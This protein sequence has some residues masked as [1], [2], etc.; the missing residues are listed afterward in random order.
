V[1]GAFDAW[2]LIVGL[3]I[4]AGLTWLVLADS[5]RR[6]VDVVEEELPSEAAWIASSLAE[7]GVVVDQGT[8]ERVLRLHRTYLASLPPDDPLA[9]PVLEP[10]PELEPKPELEPESVL[11][12]APGASTT[13]AST[14]TDVE[15]STSTSPATTT[16]AD[17]VA[18][19]AAATSS[20]DTAAASASASFPAQ[21]PPAEPRS[22][23]AR[24]RS[25]DAAGPAPDAV[26]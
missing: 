12:P 9:E 8:A 16:S 7:E 23:P 13:A 6:E 4:G 25:T 14:S 26:P 17:A 21:V 11:A 20:A 1:S 3:V 15:A 18:S 10:E 5:N 19:Q 2:L 22:Q 24:A